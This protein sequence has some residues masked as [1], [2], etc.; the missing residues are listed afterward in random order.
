MG[1]KT[2]FPIETKLITDLPDMAGAPADD[3][4]LNVYDKSAGVNKQNT[5]ENT[6]K[7][8]SKVV[9]VGPTGSGAL[10][11]CD[12]TDDDVQIQDAL[13]FAFANGLYLKMIEQ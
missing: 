8:L 13:D 9:S 1:Q 12:G 10:Y 3:D 6:F 5:I 4:I 2:T 11:E 7:K